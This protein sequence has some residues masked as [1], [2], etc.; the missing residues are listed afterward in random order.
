M[1]TLSGPALVIGARS[2]I[3]K[4][5]A[6]EFAKAGLPLILAGRGA[7]SLEADAADI[8]L[9]HSVTVRTAECDVLNVDPKA[10][11]DSLGETPRI[12]VSVVGFMGDQLRA[13]VEPAHAKVV[14][15]SNY[16]GPA[17]LLGEAAERLAAKGAEGVIIGVSSVAGDRGRSSNY[18]YGSAKAGLTAFLSGLRHRL[19]ATKILVITV[20]PGFVRTQM[21]AGMLLPKPL[22]A[23]PAEVATALL[24]AVRSRREVVYVRPVWWAIMTIINHLPEFVFKKMKV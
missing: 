12:V 4:A 20:K 13:Q 2:D 14:M 23:E 11:F 8:G 10:F 24:A 19:A 7:E 17:L 18:V 21:T 5:I 22:T 9:R 1:K 6:M 3:G 15:D 16:A